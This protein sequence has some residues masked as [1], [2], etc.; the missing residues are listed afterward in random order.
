ML[1]RDDATHNPINGH[2]PSR[3]DVSGPVKAAWSVRAPNHSNAGRGCSTTVKSG[4]QSGVSDAHDAHGTS[5]NK[6]ARWHLAIHRFPQTPV[7]SHESEAN[8]VHAPESSVISRVRCAWTLVVFF[9][10]CGTSRQSDR[11]WTQSGARPSCAAPPSPPPG[12]RDA[13]G[14]S[15]R[16]TQYSHKCGRRDVREGGRVHVARDGKYTPSPL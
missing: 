16:G 5:R 3:C 15:M 2:G 14:A 11:R 4:G 13:A 6:V 9:W 10:Q 8:A 1:N 7:S 12:V